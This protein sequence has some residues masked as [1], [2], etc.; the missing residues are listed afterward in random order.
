MNAFMNPI[1]PFG[2]AQDEIQFIVFRK[3]GNIVDPTQTWVTIDE[4]PTSINDGW[5]VHRRENTTSWVD[6]PAAYHAFAGGITFADGHAEIKRWTDS[7]VKKQG[8]IGSPRDPGSTDHAWLGERTTEI[9][10]SRR[11]R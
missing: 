6:V 10:A 1:N 5:F 11:G 4:N 9:V 3:Q 8:P 7:S 2:G